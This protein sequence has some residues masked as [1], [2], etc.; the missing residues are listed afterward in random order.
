M[1]YGDY[2]LLRTTLLERASASCENEWIFSCV[3]DIIRIKRAIIAKFI[4]I[5]KM[6]FYFVHNYVVVWGFLFFLHL[7]FPD[8]VI[9]ST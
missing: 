2:Q 8:F 6:Y 7:S 9:T 1:L 5:I 4:S 3:I